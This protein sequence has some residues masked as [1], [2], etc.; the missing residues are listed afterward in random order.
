MFLLD[1][2]N[3]FSIP[4]GGQ[5]CECLSLFAQLPNVLHRPAPGPGRLGCVTICA[6]GARGWLRLDQVSHHEA[7]SPEEPDPV[8][9][10]QLKIH[11]VFPLQT[12]HPKVVVDQ[13]V[14][15]AVRLH[16]LTQELDRRAGREGEESSRLQQTRRLWNS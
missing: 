9:I 5:Q 8:S 11:L 15:E 16:V 3:E 10:W 4:I 1:L 13:V 2:C 6:G 14:G 12:M 7:R